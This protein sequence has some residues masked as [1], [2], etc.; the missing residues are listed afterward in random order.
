MQFEIG[1]KYD[2][3]VNGQIWSFTFDGVDP[4]DENLY[5]I[6]WSTGEEEIHSKDELLPGIQ[7]VD[8]LKA[9]GIVY[10]RGITEEDQYQALR[11]VMVQPTYRFAGMV[12][13]RAMVLTCNFAPDDYRGKFNSEYMGFEYDPEKHYLNI[14]SPDPDAQVPGWI[15]DRFSVV[16]VM[17]IEHPSGR[18]ET[19]FMV[20]IGE[21]VV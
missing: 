11:S 16:A 3:V 9:A 5:F 13:P 21:E 8:T 6:T 18:N 20:E 12:V 17:R 7:K 1:T 19:K 15:M 10:P 14:S 4:D 2:T